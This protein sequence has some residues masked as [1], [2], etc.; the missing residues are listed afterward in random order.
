MLWHTA[1]A[2][3][4][5]WMAEEDRWE[6]NDGGGEGEDG[7][8]EEVDG[9]GIRGE[10]IGEEG[11][12]GS[13]EPVEAYGEGEGQGAVGCGEAA[14]ADHE[15]DRVEPADAAPCCQADQEHLRT[16]QQVNQNCWIV[17]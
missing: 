8:E 10:S 14:Y 15:A 3:V 4:V 11:V 13:A 2:A 6:C 12:E 1:E 16:T 7:I 9:R 5:M 17:L